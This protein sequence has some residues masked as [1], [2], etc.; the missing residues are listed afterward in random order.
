MTF[1]RVNITGLD[2]NDDVTLDN[3]TEINI[4]DILEKLNAADEDEDDEY[5]DWNDN[6]Q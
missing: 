1:A 2:E 3:G 6:E 4:G 5:G